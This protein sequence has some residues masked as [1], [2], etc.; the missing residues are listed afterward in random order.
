MAGVGLRGG[1][2]RASARFAVFWRA[3]A[4]I[5]SPAYPPLPNM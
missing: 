2:P 1:E 5:D 4:S 3:A